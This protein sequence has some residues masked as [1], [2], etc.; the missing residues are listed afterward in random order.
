ML[1]LNLQYFGHL[2]QSQL[3][4]KDS[5]TGKDWKKEEKGITEDKM[6]GWYHWLIGHDFE[7]EVV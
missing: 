1:K 2:I 3:I 6:V 7:Q 4:R 5:D